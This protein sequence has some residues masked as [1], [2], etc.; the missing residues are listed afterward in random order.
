MVQYRRIG[1]L[2]LEKGYITPRQLNAALKGQLRSGLR[3]GQVLAASGAVTEEQITQCLSEQYDYP[4]VA[5]DELVPQAE[6]LELIDKGFALSH[7][8]LPWRV[9][10]ET[11]ECVISDPVDIAVTDTLVRSLRLRLRFSLAPPTQ[12]YSAIAMAYGVHLA[13]ST[14]VPLPAGGNESPKRAHA[15][16]RGV[17]PQKD[18]EKIL[19][20]FAS[21]PAP[22]ARKNL[23]NQVLS[24]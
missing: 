16:K 20:A 19:E 10:G 11:L 4:M 24:Q 3:F 12:L 22:P 2:L 14:D 1:E 21:L 17:K 7:L 18:R 9:N 15:R 8:V 6:A 5:P 23:W 13:V